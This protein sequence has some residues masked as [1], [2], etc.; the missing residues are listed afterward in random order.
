MPTE[1]KPIDLNLYGTRD[2]K[3]IRENPNKTPYE[4]LQLGLSHKAYTR[5]TAEPTGAIAQAET[6]QPAEDTSAVVPSVEALQPAP[7]PDTALKPTIV[8]EVSHR[9]AQPRLGRTADALIARAQQPEGS[10]FKQVTVIGPS[11]I[12]KSMNEKQARKMVAM[13]PS[14]YK[15]V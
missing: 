11:G 14:Q 15:I 3:L 10:P 12:P 7:V 13:N 1:P 2:A 9:P 4:L 5:L 8:E 6:E